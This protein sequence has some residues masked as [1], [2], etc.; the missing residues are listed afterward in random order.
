M[1]VVLEGRE[2][3]EHSFQDSSFPCKMR[4]FTAPQRMRE[5]RSDAKSILNLESPSLW[6]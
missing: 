3:E 5:R 1:D 2:S 4:L 6:D